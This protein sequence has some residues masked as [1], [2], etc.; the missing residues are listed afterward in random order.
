MKVETIQ[1]QLTSVF[2]E[3]SEVTPV[4]PDRYTDFSYPRLLKLMRFHTERFLVKGFGHFMTMHTRTAFGMELLTVSC[5]PGEGLSVPYLLMDIMAMKKK[6]TVFVEYYDCRREPTGMPRLEEV[7]ERFAS[8]PDYPEKPKWYVQERAGYSLI[9]GGGEGEE[10]S[11]TE[12]ILSSMKAY[13]EERTAADMDP[14]GREGLAAFRE[15]MILEGNPSSS[16]LE[17][18][19]GQEGAR[20][21]M[22]K[23]VMPLEG[24][25]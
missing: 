8:L 9:K 4:P 11:L 12:M 24:D 20:D 15:R 1:K 2:L 13:R 19:F 3:G 22:M 16:V 23:C 14:A 21:F 18:V 10:D 7:H 5:M 25:R 6:R 17:K